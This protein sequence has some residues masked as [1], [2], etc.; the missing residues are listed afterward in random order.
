MDRR[1]FTLAGAALALN[2]VAAWSKTVDVDHGARIRAVDQGNANL[3]WLASAAMLVSAQRGAP[4]S[5]A[6]MARELGRPFSDLHAA[7]LRSPAGGALGTELVKPLAV[8]L[9]ARARGLASFEVDVWAGMIARGPIFI[10][11][12]TPGAQMGHAVVIAGLAGDT[13][14]QGELV[15]RLIDPAGGTAKTQKF[16]ALIKFYEGLAV[17]GIPQLLQFSD[18]DCW[19]G[20]QAG[21][22]PCVEKTASKPATRL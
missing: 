19:F 21:L 18:A 6:A 14:K 5:M 7:G 1:T 2:P 15:V 22:E 16:G 10:A 4:V 17:A 13:S 9:G 20:V 11:G 8:K 3:C 12:Y